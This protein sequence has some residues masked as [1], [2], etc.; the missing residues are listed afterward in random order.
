MEPIYHLR[1][2]PRSHVE[3][4]FRGWPSVTQIRDAIP[5]L[6]EG[7]ARHLHVTGDC[8]TKHEHFMIDE[9]TIEDGEDG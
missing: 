2:M 6:D 1:G 7:S 3:A 8:Y 4:F 9:L 5:H